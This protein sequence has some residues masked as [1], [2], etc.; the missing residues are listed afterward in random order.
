MT[1]VLDED[2]AHVALMWRHRFPTDSW[3]WELPG[4]LVDHGE[5]VATW[6]PLEHRIIVARDGRVRASD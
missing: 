1:A 3:N 4:G 5:L 6:K 2:R